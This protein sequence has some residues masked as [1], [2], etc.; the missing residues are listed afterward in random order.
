MPCRR[1]IPSFAAPPNWHS[2]AELLPNARTALRRTPHGGRRRHARKIDR[3][4]HARPS[5]G[6]GRSRSN[7]RLRR[8]RALGGSSGGRAGGLSPLSPPTFGRPRSGTG[9]EGEAGCSVQIQASECTGL[10]ISKSQTSRS[11]IL[12][13]SKSPNLQI[14]SWWLRHVSI[15]PTFS[16]CV[17]GRPL[18]WASSPTISTATIR[19]G[20]SKRLSPIRRVDC[21]RRIAR[22][23][24]RL[25]VHAPSD[26]RAR[27]RVESFGLSADADWSARTLEED[28]GRFRFEIRRFGRP[29][30]DVQLPMPGEHNVLNA[31]AAAAMAYQTE[32]RRS[33][34][35]PAWAAFRAYTGGWNGWALGKASR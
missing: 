10:Q 27:C 6:S 32:S 14:H 2:H 20:N 29:L 33:R 17:P 12:Q 31:L 34:F 18:S 19:S 28:R 24:A 11:Q 15:G 30:C 21:Q 5:A 16:T 25:P 35:R 8:A 3:R 13:F 22:G 7:G 23:A 26:H 1:R 9:G 4:G